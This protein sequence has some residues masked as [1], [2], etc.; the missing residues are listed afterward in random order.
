[1]SEAVNFDAG[2]ILISLGVPVKMR[3]FSY[4]LEAIKFCMEDRGALW[5]FTTRVYPYVAEKFTSTSSAV[6]RSMRTAIEAAFS[7]SEENACTSYFGGYVNPVS[8]KVTNSEFISLIVRRMIIESDKAGCGDKA[9]NS[10]GDK[11][12]AKSAAEIGTESEVYRL[13]TGL[14]VP[15]RLRGFAYLM[16]AISL[17][18]EDYSYLWTM[19]ERL[20]P[21]VARVYETSASSVE[22][23]IR[24]A[25]IAAF[26]RDGGKAC[27]NYFLGYVNPKSGRISNSEFISV[28]AR[29]LAVEKKTGI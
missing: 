25:I 23:S 22:R 24:S 13:L 18:V 29:R 12:S 4:L 17:C 21:T 10:L 3:G 11:I 16:T 26:S 14:C 1:M 20:Y 2:K 27:R 7:R 6:E 9:V 8:G 19:T 28:A 5:A 15:T